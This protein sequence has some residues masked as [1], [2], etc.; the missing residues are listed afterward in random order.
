MTLQELC[1]PLFLY[2]CRLNRSSR[3]GASPD[4]ARTRSDIETIFG[5]MRS[6]ASASPELAGEYDKLELP[7]MFFVDS[8]ISESDL[9][10]ASQW[11]EDRLA[12]GRNERA[13][14]EKFFDVLEETLHE[15]GEGARQRLA[16]MYACLG[17]GFTGWYA[18]QPEYLRSKA[19]ECS[20]P[21]RSMMEAEESS[22]LT[23]QAYEQV[24]TRDLIEPPGTKILYIAIALLCLVAA[25]VVTGVVGYKTARSQL[26]SDLT[27]IV[28][29]ADEEPAP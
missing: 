4:Y 25:T 14:D 6:Q 18:G 26:E 16:V 12:Y 3:K 10:F 22:R 9:P 7:L 29:I 27:T 11:H 1:E 23:P 24:D 20:V 17:L 15:K 2:I 5:T 28:Q 13:G 21:L 19:M 8:M